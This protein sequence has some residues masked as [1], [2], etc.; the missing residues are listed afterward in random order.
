MEITTEAQLIEEAKKLGH[1]F[2]GIKDSERLLPALEIFYMSGSTDDL[3]GDVDAPTGHFYRVA[4]WIV[5]TDSAGF[6]AVIAYDDTSA[7]VDAFDELS[8][9]FSAWEGE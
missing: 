7:A 1:H 4:R 8:Q 6:H 2:D 3:S 9:E 5:R